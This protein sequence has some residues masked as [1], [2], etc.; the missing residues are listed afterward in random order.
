MIDLE[1]GDLHPVLIENDAVALVI[2]RFNLC[3]RLWNM[4]IEIPGFP[5]TRQAS[6]WSVDVL[7]DEH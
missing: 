2:M 7:D 4:L 6:E 5:R 3:C 1:R